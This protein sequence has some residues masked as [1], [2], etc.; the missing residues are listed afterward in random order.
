[1]IVHKLEHKKHFIISNGIDLD[2]NHEDDRLSLSS[3]ICSK[4]LNYLCLKKSIKKNSQ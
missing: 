1:M 2:N 3:W 4:L